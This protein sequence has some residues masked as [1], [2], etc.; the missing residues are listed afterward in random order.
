MVDDKLRTLTQEA[1]HLATSSEEKDFYQRAYT[2]FSQGL[3]RHIDKIVYLKKKG[4]RKVLAPSPTLKKFHRTV[5]QLLHNCGA[6]K[7]NESVIGSVK[8]RSRKNLL[9]DKYRKYTCEVLSDGF[10][11]E[12]SKKIVMIKVDIRRDHQGQ[13]EQSCSQLGSYLHKGK[14]TTQTASGTSR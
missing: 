7:F 4:N 1:L 6:Y 2:L 13:I 9:K 11:P 3:E 12:E 5:M 14:C 8:G 10:K